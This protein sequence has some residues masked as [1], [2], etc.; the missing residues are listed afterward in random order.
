MCLSGT[1]LIAPDEFDIDHRLALKRSAAI[2]DDESSPQGPRRQ[3]E[4]RRCTNCDGTSGVLPAYAFG[5]LL[6][7]SSCSSIRG[8]SLQKARR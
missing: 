6:L 1:R 2:E 8:G 4:R 3:K 5:G 7:C